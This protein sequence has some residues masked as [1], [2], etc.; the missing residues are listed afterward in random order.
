MAAFNTATTRSGFSLTNNPCNLFFRELAANYRWPGKSRIFMVD[1][2]ATLPVFF[3]SMFCPAIADMLRKAGQQV[4]NCA[5]A[6]IPG[7]G[8]RQYYGFVFKFGG[9]AVS[10]RVTVIWSAKITPQGETAVS[11]TLTK[12]GPLLYSSSI[13]TTLPGCKTKERQRPSRL[14][15]PVYS[16]RNPE[17]PAP[18]LLSVV[19]VL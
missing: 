3:C 9:H 8:Q 18:R 11:C 19:S 10:F 16:F 2:A 17:L 4:E 15:S 13:F 1:S 12:P 5:F 7:T 14:R 6:R